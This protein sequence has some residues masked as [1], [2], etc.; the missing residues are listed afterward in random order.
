M[1]LAYGIATT[2]R[3]AGTTLCGL[4]RDEGLGNPYEWA[5]PETQASKTTEWGISPL[6]YWQSVWDRETVNGVYGI[7]AHWY[8]R[9]TSHLIADWQDCF[10][11]G[12]EVKWVF[13]TRDDVRS[14]ALS[15]LTA[16]KTNEW[17][18][19]NPYLDF[20]EREVDLHVRRFRQQN[21]DWLD[22]FGKRKGRLENVL[23]IHTESFLADQAGTVAK[24]MDHIVG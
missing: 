10:P 4:L 2:P 20:P 24:I 15:F 5:N 3:T 8:H 22:W 9:H 7:H 23:W 13:L 6:D 11:S 1:I 14:Q 12:Q 19:G 17:G 21:M 16:L 18:I